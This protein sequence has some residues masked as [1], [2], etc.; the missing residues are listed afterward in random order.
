MVLATDSKY[1]PECIYLWFPKKS[2]EIVTNGTFAHELVHI[3]DNIYKKRGMKHD[4]ENQEPY[5]HLIGYLYRELLPI[6]TPKKK[7]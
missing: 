1:F 6:V 7:K 5:A 4:L 3:A 2:E